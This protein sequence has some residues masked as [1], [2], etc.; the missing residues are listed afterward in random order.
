MAVVQIPPDGVSADFSLE[1]PGP[2]DLE[3]IG[4]IKIYFLFNIPRPSV[5]TPVLTIGGVEHPLSD[6]AM[7]PTSIT[8]VL[9]LQQS[10]PAPVQAELSVNR[11]ESLPPGTTVTIY[12]WGAQTESGEG[13][14]NPDE[15]G[16]PSTMTETIEVGTAEV[17]TWQEWNRRTGADQGV[18]S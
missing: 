15:G 2:G 7:G 5:F 17:I 18:G 3:T 8:Q 6:H 4:G 16:Q 12:A 14:L 11:T 9:Q 13:A 1:I 10:L